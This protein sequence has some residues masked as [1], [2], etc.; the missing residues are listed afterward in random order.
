MHPLQG[1]HFYECMYGPN[2]EFVE[3]LYRFFRHRYPLRFGDFPYVFGRVARFVT[4]EVPHPYRKFPI[5]SYSRGQMEDVF[6][7]LRKRVYRVYGEMFPYD[8]F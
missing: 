6:H 3:T 8:G 5:A 4:T 7:R 2:G 1:K